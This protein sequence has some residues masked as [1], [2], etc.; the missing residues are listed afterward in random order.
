MMRTLKTWTLLIACAI[1]ATLSGTSARAQEGVEGGFPDRWPYPLPVEIPQP[2]PN[3]DFQVVAFAGTVVGVALHPPTISVGR[4]DVQITSVTIMVA[5]EGLIRP[6]DFELGET[7]GVIALKER[8]GR[9]NPEPGDPEPLLGVFI[10]KLEPPAR[11]WLRRRDHRVGG[12]IDSLDPGIKSFYLRDGALEVRTDDDTVFADLTTTGLSFD[13]LRIDQLVV[14]RG[15]WITTGSVFDA[16]W[17]HIGGPRRRHD[18]VTSEPLTLLHGFLMNKTGPAEWLLNTG[19][20]ILLPARVKIHGFPHQRV[21]R[22]DVEVGEFL[23]VAGLDDP[24]PIEAVGDT[25]EAVRIHARPAIVNRIST[26]TLS[27]RANGL[28]VQTNPGTVFVG[29]H[30]ALR[31]FG[32]LSIGDLVRLRGAFPTTDTLIAT[33]VTLCHTARISPRIPDLN[34]VTGWRDADGAWHMR[35]TTNSLAFGYIDFPVDMMPGVEGAIYRVR[36]TLACDVDNPWEAP[37]VRLRFMAQDGQIAQTL[38]ITSAGDA[39]HS[40]TPGGR[41]YEHVI[42]SPPFD[43][44][45]GEDAND[46]YFAFD[47]I[48]MD[49]DNRARARLSVLS[50]VVEAFDPADIQALETLVNDDFDDGPGDWRYV[51][52]PDDFPGAINRV[53]SG[54]LGLRP[55]AHYSFGFWERLCEGVAL[56][57]GELYRARFL[58]R[59]NA[60]RPL[61]VP[62]ARVRLNSGGLASIVNICSVGDGRMMPGEDGAVYEAF[63]SVPLDAAASDGP[64]L[65]FDL[66]HLDP[67]DDLGVEL[68]LDQAILERVTLAP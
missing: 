25:I 8:V 61:E 36:T 52:V 33:T 22:G 64:V 37:R 44:N 27:F 4:R 39:I 15:D 29:Q 45:A 38:A 20:T 54:G 41:D 59:S 21:S 1:A 26:P 47:L 23:V 63:L 62:G 43:V 17:V 51:S 53:T 24:A 3:P 13:D 2:P 10:G 56:Q 48:N 19:E 57:Q 40:P 7:V 65:A 28:H 50:M 42:V 67:D 60:R 35:C 18:S 32:D 6:G 9:P 49:P 55:R 68:I 34:P 5:P 12:V 30:G 66:L 14:A 16:A 58:L 46:M 31:S 11:E